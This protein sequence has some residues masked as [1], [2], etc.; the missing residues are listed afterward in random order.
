M[1]NIGIP[2]K[3]QYRRSLMNK[4]ENVAHRIRRKAYCFMHGDDGSTILWFTIQQMRTTIKEMK[5]RHQLKK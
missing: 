1:K 4:A 5:A 3:N 2:A